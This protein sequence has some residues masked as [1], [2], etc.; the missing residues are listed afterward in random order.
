MHKAPYLRK[1]VLDPDRPIRNAVGPK[2]AELR[3]QAGMFQEELGRRLT[4]LG[5]PIGRKQVIDLESQRRELNDLEIISISKVLGVDP[6]VFY[7]FLSE[8]VAEETGGSGQNS[9]P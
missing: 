8:R 6:I 9:T 2:V 1:R 5:H 4:A 3:R 7:K